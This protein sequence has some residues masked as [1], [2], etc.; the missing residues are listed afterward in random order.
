MEEHSKPFLTPTLLKPFQQYISNLIHV[1]GDMPA[2]Y[3]IDIR[4]KC[5]K[6]FEKLPH[7]IHLNTRL[8]GSKF[9]VY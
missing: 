3:D 4:D 6:I 2:S 9:S 8:T 1:F 5:F 7:Y